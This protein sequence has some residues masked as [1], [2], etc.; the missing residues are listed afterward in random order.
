MP[1]FTIL[2]AQESTYYGSVDVEADTWTDAV[3]G[4]EAADWYDAC[5]REEDASERRVVSVEDGEGLVFAEDINFDCEMV[6]YMSVVVRLRHILEMLDGRDEA[7]ENYIYELAYASR[8]PI[9]RTKKGAS[10]DAG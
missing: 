9:F 10:D 3:R 4:L 5:V 2:L 7:L 1:V 8:D 6:H